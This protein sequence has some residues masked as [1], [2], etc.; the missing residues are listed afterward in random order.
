MNPRLVLKTFTYGVMHL[1]VAT[2]VSY[3]ITGDIL[4]SLSIGIVEPIIQTIMFS[5]HEY[6]WEALSN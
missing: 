5:I 2:C 6:L 4:I 1:C 3:F